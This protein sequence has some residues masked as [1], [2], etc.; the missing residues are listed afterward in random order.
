VA[1]PVGGAA[2]GHP[3]RNGLTAPRPIGG[4]LRRRAR[5]AAE[6]STSDNDMLLLP[7]SGSSVV[8]RKPEVAI[9]D[10]SAV[11]ANS[12]PTSSVR[13]H[14]E[15]SRPSIQPSDADIEVFK[16][17]AEH[18]RQDLREFWVRNNMYLLVTG[19]LV[20]VFASL[21]DKGAYRL[22]LPAFGL[23]VSIFWFAVSYGSSRWLQIWRDELCKIDRELDR[24]Q[25]FYRVEQCGR[26]IRSVWSPSWVTQFLP[27]VVGVGWLALLIFAVA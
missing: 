13:D 16:M 21:G 15:K 26:V 1:D 11:D 2:A 9:M 4:E 17:V 19:V 25:V 20:S 3:P 27:V 8:A 24:F 22:A 7:S 14:G 10:G 12:A 5:I 18:F 23:L 6:I